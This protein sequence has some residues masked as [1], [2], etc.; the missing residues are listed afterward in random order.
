[1][2]PP[3]CSGAAAAN[4]AIANAQAIAGNAPKRAARLNHSKKTRIFIFVFISSPPPAAAAPPPPPPRPPPPPPREPMLDEPREL[5]ERALL[6][7]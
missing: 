5:L 3:V 6:P 4:G 7:L 2:A 1:M